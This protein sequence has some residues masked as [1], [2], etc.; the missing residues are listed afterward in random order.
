MTVPNLLTLSR[1]LLTPLL[2]WF[3]VRRRL[4][5]ALVVFFIA[6][7]TD[8]LDGAIARLFHQKSKFGAV[9]DPLADKFLLVSS[10]LILGHLSLIP[11]WLVII[12]VA[13]DGLIVLGTTLLFV[14]RF[15]LEVRPSVLG[16]LTTLTQLLS[17]VLALSSSLTSLPPWNYLL[18]FL[19]TAVLSVATGVQYVRRGISVVRS[20]LSER[21]TKP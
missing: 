10:F 17:V 11:G 6:G 20:Q 15:Q 1:I 16:K 2:M 14:L 21:R 9:L 19:I 5:E 4:N 7:M 12:A 8:I 3:L 13:R 18:L